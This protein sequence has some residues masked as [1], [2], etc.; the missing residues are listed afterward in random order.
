[1]ST[2]APYRFGQFELN[3]RTRQL[4]VDGRPAVLG[5]RA[6][7]VLLALIERRDRV[8]AKDEL[9]DIVWPGLVVEENNLQVQVSTLRKLLGIGAIATVPGRGYQFTLPL[10]PN[11][12][13]SM[14]GDTSGTP[15][16]GLPGKPSIAVLPFA[17]MT[18]DADD[19]YFIDGVTED[20]I[21]ELSRFRSLF[22]I[23][24]NSSF[25]YKGK[26]IDVRQVARELGVRYV[27]EGSA[28]KVSNRVRVT[29]QLVDAMT[30]RHIWAERY[31][32]TLADIF[33]VQEEITQGIVTAIAP[34]IEVSERQKARRSRP[35]SLNAYEIAVRANAHVW[36]AVI[37]SDRSLRD[38]AYREAKEALAIDPKSARAFNVLAF[39]QYLNVSFRTA[40]DLEAAWTEGMSAA[41]FAIEQDSSDSEGY[42]RKGL[43]LSVAPDQYRLNDALINLRAAHELNSNDVN[44]LTVLG[45]CEAITGHP[46]RGIEYL[47][48]AI[49]NAPRDPLRF[50]ARANLATAYSLVKDYGQT[51]RFASLAANE[52]PNFALS[53]VMLAIGYVG[54]A[55]LESATT[56]FNNA[57]R[58]APEYVESRLNG[59]VPYQNLSDRQAFTAFLR[60]AA[61]LDD[62]SAADAHR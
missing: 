20:I 36:D 44:V 57:R 21:T 26:S 27:L 11:E 18:A 40:T 30:G 2:N 1:M 14:V 22:V 59:S 43:L 6:F 17:N 54:L 48:Q 25:S 38:Q 13:S 5:A 19:E 16:L 9:L 55:D 31:D 46:A 3:P 39:V 62:P 35:G 60:V 41:S 47:L 52:A 33:S 7:D 34:E 12:E 24:R 4:V 53:H 8:V 51:V 15:D 58:L 61:G 50:A 28:R 49:R 42:L 45:W 32:R 56:A 37:K 29:G 10:S 23:A